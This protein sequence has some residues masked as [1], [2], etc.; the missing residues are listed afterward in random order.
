[1]KRLFTQ[2]VLVQRPEKTTQGW[3]TDTDWVEVWIY[4]G[5][6]S[7]TYN[8]TFNPETKT[9]QNVVS[10]RFLLFLHPQADIQKDDK[11]TVANKTFLVLDVVPLDDCKITHHLEVYL[12]TFQ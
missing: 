10:Q 11:I 2:D 12:Q 1:M 8:P 7:T 6:L 4:R 3:L 9:T 5:R